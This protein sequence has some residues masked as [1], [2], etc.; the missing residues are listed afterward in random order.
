MKIAQ[1]IYDFLDIG[2][3]PHPSDCIFVL[4]GKQER[5]I[6]GITMWRFGYA[7]RLI[8]SVARY[9]WRKFRELNLD[10]DGGLEVAASQTAPEKRHFLVCL[11]RES[12]SCVPTSMGHFGTISEARALA[13]HLRNSSVRSLLVVS[14]P[15]HLRRTALAFRR[16]F[17]K[18]G[19]LLNFVAIPEKIALNSHDARAE[20]WSEF[21]KYLLSLLVL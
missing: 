19:I 5:K 16:A 12:T 17:R 1:M 11:D 10:S 21:W 3:S 7:P 6:H 15:I 4:A 2:K 9:E 13:G 18:S 14:S 20:I 8:I